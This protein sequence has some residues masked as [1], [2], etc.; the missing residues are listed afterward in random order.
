MSIQKTIV[1]EHN[2]NKVVSQP[3]T[4]K[5]ACIVDDERYR[6]GGLATGA[7]KALIKMFEGTVLTEEVIDSEIEIKTLKK[8]ISK[9]LDWY[10]GIDD[11]VKNS[12]SPHPESQEVG[13]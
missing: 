12:S 7:R 6:D 5:H 3:F 1:F 13:V 11:E 4:F 2:S 10:L 8:A 9:I